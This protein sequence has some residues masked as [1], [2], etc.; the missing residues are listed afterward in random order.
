[1]AAQACSQ[2]GNVLSSGHADV[3][4]LPKLSCLYHDPSK[5]RVVVGACARRIDPPFMLLWHPTNP[6]FFFLI[7]PKSCSV[8][9]DCGRSFKSTNGLSLNRNYCVNRPSQAPYGDYFHGD[10]INGP[11]TPDSEG[12][13]VFRF[14]EILKPK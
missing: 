7:M 1:M 13:D 10:H 3:P 4:V 12:N 9:P 6:P 8:C 2:K 5:S 14:G 11:G